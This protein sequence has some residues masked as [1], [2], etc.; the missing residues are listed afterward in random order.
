MGQL[1]KS[2]A[3]LS[4]FPQQAYSEIVIF[5]QVSLDAEFSGGIMEL[6]AVQLASACIRLVGP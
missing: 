4:P 1:A 3:L 2:T 6:S 5:Q